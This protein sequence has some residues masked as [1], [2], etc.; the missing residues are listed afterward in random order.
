MK[1]KMHH[2]W[3]KTVDAEAGSDIEALVTELFIFMIFSLL[4][5]H[6]HKIDLGVMFVCMMF[7]AG[8]CLIPITMSIMQIV[9]IWA[10][11]RKKIDHE[12]SKT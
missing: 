3:A 12:N 1:I 6:A 10:S 4:A 5:W 2:Y 7:G 8:I 11:K 9:R